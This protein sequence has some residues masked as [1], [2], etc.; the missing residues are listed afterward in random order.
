[1]TDK[2]NEKLEKFFSKDFILKYKNLIILQNEDGTYDLF[3]RYCIT[4]WKNRYKI[5]FRYNSNEKIFSSIKNAVTWCIFDYRNRFT[6]CNRIEYL[7]KILSSIDNGIVIHKSLL[8]K[9][10]ID[11]S[12]KLIYAS[13]LSEEISRKKYMQEEMNSFIVQSRIWQSE[14]FSVK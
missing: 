11:Y 13:K 14:K 10:S 12:D 4:K 9:K 2:N 5:I 8:N 1:M 6:E 3:D 7:D